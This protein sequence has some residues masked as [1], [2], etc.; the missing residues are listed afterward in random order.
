MGT[1][2]VFCGW[3]WC[4]VGGYGVLWVPVWCSVGTDMVSCGRV[5]CRK[6]HYSDVV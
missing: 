6:V 3:V 2:M 5:W 4:P 1:G